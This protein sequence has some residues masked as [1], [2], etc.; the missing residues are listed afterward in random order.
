MCHQSVTDMNQPS[1]T[2]TYQQKILFL[3]DKWKDADPRQQF[4]TDII[5]EIQKIEK[6]PNNLCILM[7]DANESIDDKSGSIRKI[8]AQTSLVD[9]F[10][11]VAEEPERLATYTRGRK[12]IDY[13]LTSQALVQ[14][15][16]RVGYLAFFKSN[17][18]NHRGMFLDIQKPS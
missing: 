7:F 8:M 5:E 17:N 10:S 6:D 2:A 9:T 15:V 4:I 18:S 16:S 1:T 12:R 13:I 3:K 11:Q 14:Y